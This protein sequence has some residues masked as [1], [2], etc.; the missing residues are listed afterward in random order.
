MEGEDGCY[1]TFFDLVGQHRMKE[2]DITD[3]GYE[4]VHGVDEGEDEAEVTEGHGP[5]REAEHGDITLQ[6]RDVSHVLRTRPVVNLEL[7][8]CYDRTSLTKNGWQLVV[9]VIICD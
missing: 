3:C 9:Q 4:A 5:A 7:N 1:I 8:A 6:P 2:G